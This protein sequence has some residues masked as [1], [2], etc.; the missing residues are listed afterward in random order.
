MKALNLIL[1]IAVAVSVAGAYFAGR[2]VGDYDA[3]KMHARAGGLQV[4]SERAD[5]LYI[6]GRVADL[7][8]DSK[9]LDALRVLE[10]FARLDAP[11]VDE[12]MKASDCSWWIA[13]SEERRIALERY[14]KAY[15]G[16]EATRSTK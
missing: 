5:R 14:V 16:S 11:A 2:Y 10:Q 1:P 3:Q 4:S 7:L 9:S 6:A 15:G 8:K 13:A 12:C